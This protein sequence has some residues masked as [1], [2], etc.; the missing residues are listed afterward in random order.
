MNKK[1]KYKTITVDEETYK[2][3][4]L[5]SIGERRTISAIVTFMLDEYIKHQKAS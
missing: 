1:K 5:L 3:I 4:K 2:K